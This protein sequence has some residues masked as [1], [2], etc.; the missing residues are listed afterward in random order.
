MMLQNLMNSYFNNNKR[1]LSESNSLIP[2]LNISKEKPVKIKDSKWIIEEKTATRIY[3]FKSRKQKE[4]F[5]VEII[6]YCRESDCDLEVTFTKT[7][8]KVVINSLSPSISNLEFDCIKD[9][10]KIRK[11]VMYYFAKKE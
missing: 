1:L 4:S 7:E 5:I 2:V 10:K 9:I 6:K 8:V 11:D 3:K